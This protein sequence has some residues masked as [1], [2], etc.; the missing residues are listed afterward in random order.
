[1]PTKLSRDPADLFVVLWDSLPDEVFSGLKAHSWYEDAT[2]SERATRI[3]EEVLGA[4]E[5]S[6]ALLNEL[7]GGDQSLAFT[8]ARGIDQ[9]LEY[10]NPYSGVYEQDRLYALSIRYEANARLNDET[11][12]A[13]LFA[14][15]FPGRPP[16]V[17]TKQ[18]YFGLVRIPDAVW[19]TVDHRRIPTESDV[20]V[21]ASSRRNATVPVGCMPFVEE[22]DELEITKTRRGRR[23]NYRGYRIAPVA[24]TLRGRIEPMLEALDA[25]G[26]RVGVV[27]EACLSDELRDAW[28]N[29]LADRDDEGLEWMLIG[30]GP[31]GRLEPPAN[32]AVLVD[33]IGRTLIEQDKLHDFTL[34]G[35]QLRD[36]KLDDRL[37]TIRRAEDIQPGKRLQLRESDFGRIAIL[38]CQDV[39]ERDVATR[40]AA[41]GVS[42]VF[43][44]IFSPAMQ[45]VSVTPPAPSWVIHAAASHAADVGSWLVIAT[46][47][48]VAR[49]IDPTASS[50]ATSAVVGPR[51][52]RDDWATENRYGQA[53][54]ADDVCLFRVPAAL[55]SRFTDYL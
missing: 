17:P 13:L 21:D 24:S 3:R 37:G 42:H 33:R 26:A 11:D 41:C 23:L 49:A 6:E 16:G 2:L 4:G 45:K 34:S 53:A 35:R 7:V 50:H 28:V 12:G 51:E 44:P 36:W 31:V 54:Q 47:L 25:K 19:Q 10:A 52:D 39:N 48:A 20:N 55:V 40:L 1:M 5:V 8:T 43:V 22:Y 38:V 27:P 15:C 30:T 46:C 9:A 32:R 14:C 29:A 18:Q